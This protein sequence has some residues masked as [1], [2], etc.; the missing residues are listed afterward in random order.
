MKY[1]ICLSV[2]TQHVNAQLS[3]I[4]VLGSLSTINN[5][6]YRMNGTGDYGI[7]F[8]QKIG[9]FWSGNI[10]IANNTT[11]FNIIPR[12]VNDYTDESNKYKSYQI[13]VNFNALTAIRTLLAG[14]RSAIGSKKI[15]LSGFKWYL[16]SGLEYLKIDKVPIDK[17]SDTKVTNIYGGMGFEIYRLGRGASRRYAALVPFFE[18]RYYYNTSGGYYSSPVSHV[19]FNKISTALGLKF[20]F[21]LPER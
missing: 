14:G 20:T 4:E 19:N 12:K 16:N 6:L 8:N 11:N 1:F 9:W 5:P 7:R 13:G 2:L 10:E 15:S 17:Q 3:S 21:G 18:I